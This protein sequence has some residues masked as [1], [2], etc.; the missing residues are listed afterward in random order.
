MTFKSHRQPH[1]D[2]NTAQNYQCK[3]PVALAKPAPLAKS[4]KTSEGFRVSLAALNCPAEAVGCSLQ[5]K[6]PKQ[7]VANGQNPKSMEQFYKVS[8]SAVSSGV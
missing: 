8:T 5:L 4:D 7:L 2:S 6:V 3:H 1:T